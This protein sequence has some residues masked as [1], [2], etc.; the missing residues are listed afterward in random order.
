MRLLTVHPGAYYHI[1]SFEGARFAHYFDEFVRPEELSS[2]QI[3]DFDVLLIP[4]RTP[5]D[6]ILPH[7]D[8]LLRYL[9]AGGTIVSTGESHSEL[10]LPNVRFTPQPTNWWWWLTPDAD[11]G[12]RATNSGH[13]LFRFLPERDLTWHLHGWFDPPD[14]VTVLA[15]NEIGKPILYIDDV[16]TKGRLIVTSL[17]PFYH[18]GSHFMPAT[19]RFLTGFLPWMREHASRRVEATSPR[20]Q[21]APLKVQGSAHAL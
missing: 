19:S 6:R 7:K 4:C 3:E 15:V 14:G 21:R 17:D 18:H 13:S 1:E 10:Y 8:Q 16:S 2:V 12:V 5:A 9:D 11:L 20:A